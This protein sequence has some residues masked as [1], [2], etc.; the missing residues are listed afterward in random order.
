[1]RTRHGKHCPKALTRLRGD[2]EAATLLVIRWLT[3]IPEKEA[4]SI[5]TVVEVDM[6]THNIQRVVLVDKYSYSGNCVGKVVVALPVKAHDELCTA[7]AAANADTEAIPGGNALVL[8]NKV[9]FISG[10]LGDRYR[11]QGDWHM[12][13]LREDASKLFKF[14]AI[15]VYLIRGTPYRIH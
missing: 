4:S 9:D 13:K 12:Q 7:S 10:A 2:H 1:M 14:Q 5:R 6:L 11:L 8:A 15:V 3:F